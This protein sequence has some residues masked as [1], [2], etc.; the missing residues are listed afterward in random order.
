MEIAHHLNPTL[1]SAETLKNGGDGVPDQVK[2]RTKLSLL[3]LWQVWQW[4]LC[5]VGLGCQ[6]HHTAVLQP[7]VLVNWKNTHFY[8]SQGVFYPSEN[9]RETEDKRR[10]KWQKESRVERIWNWHVWWGVIL[11]SLLLKEIVP[12]PP[13]VID[14]ETW[15]CGEVKLSST[16][17]KQWKWDPPSFLHT[18]EADRSVLI[19]SPRLTEAV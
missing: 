5:W 1:G 8:H 18:T 19:L 17:W 3:L 12:Q 9:R 7:L 6:H 11:Q 10:R 13:H 2:T 4:V 15:R 14:K 16:H